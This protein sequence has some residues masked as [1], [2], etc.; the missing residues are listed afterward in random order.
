MVGT[1][2]ARPALAARAGSR[3]VRIANAALHAK[4]ARSESAGGSASTSCVSTNDRARGTAPP[5]GELSSPTAWLVESSRSAI[6]AKVDGS[7][8]LL[9]KVVRSG[10]ARRRRSRDQLRGHA[11]AGSQGR[12]IV[13]DV[14]AAMGACSSSA[15]SIQQPLGGVGETLRSSALQST[16]MLKAAQSAGGERLRG[17]P[18][19]SATRT[20]RSSS[21]HQRAWC[22]IHELNSNGRAARDG[23]ERRT[24]LRP[25]AARASIRGASTA[26]HVRPSRTH[27]GARRRL[28]PS[29]RRRVLCAVERQPQASARPVRCRTPQ[30]ATARLAPARAPPP[31]TRGLTT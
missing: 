2:R 4:P 19:T 9:T 20:W 3:R 27:V 31:F 26:C 11:H 14:G 28:C 30:A 18:L 15:S 10:A 17:V 6:Q 16:T 24:N 7:R 13:A 5:V 23:C 8:A 25:P 29:A 21:S 22:E 1:P 12:A